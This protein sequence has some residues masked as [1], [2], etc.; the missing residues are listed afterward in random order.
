MNNAQE[1]A[2]ILHDEGLTDGRIGELVEVSREYINKIRS[3][4]KVA[5]MN[6]TESLEAILDTLPNTSGGT[7]HTAPTKQNTGPL[8]APAQFTLTDKHLLWG[9][10]IVMGLLVIAAIWGVYH[11][12]QE[13]KQKRDT[14]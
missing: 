10:A 9:A 4:K 6:L 13:N 1:I 12:Y 14:P 8:D 11:V 3:G 7:T 2:N 5:S